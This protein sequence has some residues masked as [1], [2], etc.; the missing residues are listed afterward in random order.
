MPAR[1][2]AAIQ[3][4]RDFVNCLRSHEWERAYELTAQKSNMGKN[5][6][7]FQ[8]IVRQ[9]WPTATPASIRFLTVHPF[10]SYGNRLR[11]WAYGQTIDPQELWLDFS[12]DGLPFQV[13]ERRWVAGGFLPEPCGLSGGDV[14]TAR[15]VARP[16]RQ[17]GLK[18]A[19]V[20]SDAERR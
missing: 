10:Q 15:I 11:R 2:E 6:A 8:S 5:F 1:P 3:T 7:E 13:R 20:D 16:W 17:T 4:A 9:Q 12:V 18:T 14:A 19:C